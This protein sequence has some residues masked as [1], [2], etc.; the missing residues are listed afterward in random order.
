MMVTGC[1]YTSNT[2]PS[3]RG[4]C[5]M[6]PDLKTMQRRRSVVLLLLH[7]PYQPVLSRFHA[8]LHASSLSPSSF[9]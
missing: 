9:L 5:P 1:T 3:V 7:R 6:H 2:P 8:P 4:V